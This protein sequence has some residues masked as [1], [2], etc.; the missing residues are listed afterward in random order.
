MLGP[1]HPLIG[2]HACGQA[3]EAL[4]EAGHD[5]EVVRS[6]GWKALPDLLNQTP[7]RRA[8]RELTGRN[9]V[10]VLVLDD[11]EVVAGSREII[12]WARANPAAG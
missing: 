7:G 11:D 12:D 8:V 1:S 2:D 10:P 9:D 4:L 5:P 6:Y 3:R